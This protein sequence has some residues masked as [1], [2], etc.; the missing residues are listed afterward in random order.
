MQRIVTRGMGENHILITR[1][2]GVGRI[3]QQF[4]KVMR[5]VSKLGRELLM[6]SKWKK[7]DCA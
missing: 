7:I 6:V 4:Y 1:G 2:Y 5:L 3:V